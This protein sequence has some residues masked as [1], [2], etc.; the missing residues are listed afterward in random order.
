[1]GRSIF[2]AYTRNDFKK[3]NEPLYY[4]KLVWFWKK[5]LS[6]ENV[7]VLKTDKAVLNK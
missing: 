1:M 2:A 6:V 4:A 7:L 3:L 5:S